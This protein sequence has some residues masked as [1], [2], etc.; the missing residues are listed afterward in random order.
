MNS[1]TDFM[2]SVFLLQMP[3]LLQFLF[4]NDLADDINIPKDTITKM[5]KNVIHPISSLN[6]P[7]S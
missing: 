1:G 5:I 6:F 3:N 7:D 4:A 2:V